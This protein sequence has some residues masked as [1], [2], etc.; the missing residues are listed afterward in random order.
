MK[1]AYHEIKRLEKK[2]E[3]MRLVNRAKSILMTEKSMSE[4]DAHRYIEKTAMDRRV[5]RGQV[6]EEIIDFYTA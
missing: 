6:A 5:S 4:P 1:K 3:E 2:I